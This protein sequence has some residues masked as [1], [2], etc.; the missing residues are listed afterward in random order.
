METDRVVYGWDL[1]VLLTLAIHESG[2]AMSVKELVAMVEALGGTFQGRASQVVSDALRAEMRKR[3][4]VR[5]SRG[6]YQ[7]GVIPRSTRDRLRR[8]A[9]GVHARLGAATGSLGQSHVA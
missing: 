7:A 5:V 8:R 1:R 4:V 9:R 3:R 2:R 6:I